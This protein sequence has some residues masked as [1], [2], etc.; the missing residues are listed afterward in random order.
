MQEL[1]IRGERWSRKR[2]HKLR[3]NRRIWAYFGGKFKSFQF[4]M[5]LSLGCLVSKLAL[6]IFPSRKCSNWSGS[7]HVLQIFWLRIYGPMAQPPIYIEQPWL[8]HPCMQILQC[9]LEVQRQ[10][11]WKISEAEQQSLPGSRCRY[12]QRQ[13]NSNSRCDGCVHPS[14]VDNRWRS[15]GR[16]KVREVDFEI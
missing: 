15:S 7:A 8:E 11:V 9:G 14:S 1:S 13:W 2:W 16:W 6:F 5:S 4:G 12:R 3:R 10:K